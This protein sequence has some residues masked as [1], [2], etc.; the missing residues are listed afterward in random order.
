M[1][2]GKNE[3]YHKHFI[4]EKPFRKKLQTNRG[5]TNT[6]DPLLDH[7][8]L[9]SAAARLYVSKKVKRLLKY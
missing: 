7:F 4:R 5:Y 8:G 1:N 9:I 2:G 6:C 3:P